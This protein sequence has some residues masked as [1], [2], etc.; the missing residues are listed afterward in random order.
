M[1]EPFSHS[2]DPSTAFDRLFARMRQQ[3]EFPGLSGVVSRILNLSS[4]DR[5]SVASLT[6]EILKDVGLTQRLLRLVNTVHYSRGQAIRTVSRAVSLVGFNGIRNLTLSLVLLEHMRDRAHAARLREEFLRVLVAGAFAR[7]LAG[8][9]GDGEEAFIAAMFRNLGRLLAEFYFSDDA[10]KVRE[11]MAAQPG[12]SETAASIEVYGVSHEQL[13]LK[14]ARLWGLPDIVLRALRTPVDSAIPQEGGLPPD[15]RLQWTAQAANELARTVLDGDPKE[16]GERLQKVC[17]RHGR[18]LE[19][20][21]PQAL[22]AVARA[23]EQF[24]DL[25]ATLGLDV[26]EASPTARMLRAVSGQLAPAA[27][28]ASPASGGGPLHAA[29]GSQG[30]ASGDPGLPGSSETAESGELLTTPGALGPPSVLPEDLEDDGTSVSSAHRSLDGLMAG[31]QDV[32]SAMVEDHRLVDILRMVLEAMLRAM[33]F[34][35]VVFCMRDPKAEALTGR[36]GLGSGVESIVRVFHVNLAAP[37]RDLFAAVCAKGADTLIT[38]AAEPR[39]RDRLPA[40]FHDSVGA[41]TF[42][43]LPL[44]QAG[45]PF[46]LIYADRCFGRPPL[47]IDDRELALLR[48]LR[49]QAVLAF[50]QSRG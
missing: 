11:R 15:E 38:D 39:V 25:A 4:S 10:R 21:V 40:W 26:D 19:L 29:A 43:V 47:V 41:S 34:D 2:S 8:H 42:L 48:T 31:I 36:V 37:G 13:A 35:R 6:N 32:A 3:G 20:S 24:G 14:V 30:R 49:N 44:R 9:H 28:N 46:G 5:E 22:R 17:E 18:A 23:R 33:D 27:A 45:A 16:Q 7:E 1:S 12:L 50:K